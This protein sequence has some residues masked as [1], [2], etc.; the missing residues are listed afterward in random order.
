MVV[1]KKNGVK[2][3]FDISKVRRSI[4]NAAGDCGMIMTES[5]LSNACRMIENTI[6]DHGNNETSSYE[7]FGV[8]VFKLN[9]LNYKKVAQSY[10][11]GALGLTK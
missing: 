6:K 9:E 2:E 4:A 1:R 5:D 11:N 7:V 8:V 10:V 3:D